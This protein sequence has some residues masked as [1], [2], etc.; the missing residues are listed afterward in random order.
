MKGTALE[1][2]IVLHLLEAAGC[3]EALIISSRI[4]TRGW[5]SLGFRLGAFE[6]DNVAWHNLNLLKWGAE[7]SSI[8]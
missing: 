8:I 7:T 3:P 6:N 2:G 4:V 5:L 1:K